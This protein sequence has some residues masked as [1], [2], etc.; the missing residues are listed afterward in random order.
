MLEFKKITGGLFETNAYLIQATNGSL[1]V[2]APD[3]AAS[4]FADEKIDALLLTHGHFDHTIDAAKIVARHGCKVFCHHDSYPMVS[5]P[6]FFRRHGFGL[7]VEPVE[8]DHFLDEGEPLLLN[9]LEFRLL[10]APGHCPGSIIFFHE[11]TLEAF[12]GDV[13]FS[14]GVGRWDLPG[15]DKDILFT[16]IREKVYAL[17]DETI[18]HPGHGPS[19]RLGDEKKT[20]PFVSVD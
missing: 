9:G 13:L 20:N 4:A 16:S 12:G 18:I 19:F 11:P 6:D 14:G 17:P 7:E 3:G 10:L 1:L 8:V 2:D 5:E 15:G